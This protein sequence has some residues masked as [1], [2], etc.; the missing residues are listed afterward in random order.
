MPLGTINGGQGLL[1]VKTGQVDKSLQAGGWGQMVWDL[2]S[3]EVW[4]L[5]LS[6][7][8]LA[9]DGAEALLVAFSPRESRDPKAVSSSP[10]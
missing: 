10:A 1:N 4:K 9:R 3:I 8:T 5:C 6:K 2:L 7:E